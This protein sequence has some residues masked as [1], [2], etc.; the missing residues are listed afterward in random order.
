MQ[1]AIPVEKLRLSSRLGLAGYFKAKKKLFH[2]GQPPNSTFKIFGANSKNSV[3]VYFAIGLCLNFGNK[4]SVDLSD[5]VVQ[6]I[7]A[8]TLHIL[9][10]FFHFG[11][12]SNATF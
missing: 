1:H 10:N 7:Q 2:F 8:P 5:N 9:L 4:T 6:L 11:Q 12:P 3:G